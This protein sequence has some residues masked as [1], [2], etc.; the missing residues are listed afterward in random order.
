MPLHPV[1][2]ELLRAVGPMAVSSANISGRPPATTAEQAQSQ[3]SESV[4]VF[5]DAGPSPVGVAS[6]VVDLTGE[7]P[8]VRRIGAVSVDQLRAVLPEIEVPAELLPAAEPQPADIA[9]AP[10]ASDGTPDPVAGDGP[11]GDP[12]SALAQTTMLSGHEPTDETAAT[13]PA[14][15]GAPSARHAERSTTDI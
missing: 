15:D 11:E 4:A 7:V 8:M 5:L 13:E 9:D 12:D 3:L 1:A 6:T 14:P 10:G 2:L